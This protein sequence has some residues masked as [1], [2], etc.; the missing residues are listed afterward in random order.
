MVGQCHKNSQQRILNELK[1]LLNLMKILQKTMMKKV[2]I[3]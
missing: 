2:I 3:L 1:I